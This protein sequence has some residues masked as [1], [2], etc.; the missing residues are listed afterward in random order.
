M[1]SNGSPEA[2]LKGWACGV[3]ASPRRTG[4]SS[5]YRTQFTNFSLLM[6]WLSLKLRI[7]TSILLFKRKEKPPFDKLHGLFKRHIGGRR[8]ESVEMVRHDDECVQEEPPLLAIVKDGL[9]EQFRGGRDLKKTVALRR[10]SGDKIRSSF[11]RC[12]S[13]IGSINEMPA[14]KATSIAGS[15][16]G[17]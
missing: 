16:S 4:F 8:D 17:A 9:L 5:M 7:H 1:G 3:E 10:Y 15:H 14:A 12:E 11:L 2:E 13:H 6:I